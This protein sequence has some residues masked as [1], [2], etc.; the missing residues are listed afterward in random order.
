MITCHH[1][2]SGKN[3]NI[4]ITDELFEDVARFIYLETTLTN[5][6]AIYNEIKSRLNSGNI[7]YHSIQNLSS[8][9]I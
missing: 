9:L 5:K 2:N 7:C 1:Q 8:R 3:Q 6:N 4:R